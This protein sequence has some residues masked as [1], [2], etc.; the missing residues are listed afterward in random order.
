MSKAYAVTVGAGLSAD[1]RE[2]KQ[3]GVQ[4]TAVV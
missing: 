4:A 2:W 3:T 1:G